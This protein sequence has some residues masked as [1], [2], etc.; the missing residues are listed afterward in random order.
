M[1][2]LAGV[3]LVVL[4]AAA[5]A[6]DVRTWRVGDA[7]HPWRAVPV[8]TIVSWGQGWAVEVLMDEDGDGLID[9]D[10]VE[11]IDDDGDG[12]FNEDP[13][14]EQRD[15]DGDGLVNEDPRN[16]IDDD[17]DGLIDE[18]PPEIFDNDRDGL[19]NEDGPD[20][21]IDN[22]G[23]G[24]LN[25]D[26]LWT[27]T[28]D[29]YDGRLNEDPPEPGGPESQVD[30]DGDGLVNEDPYGPMTGTR[31]TDLLR[32]DPVGDDDCYRLP[33]NVLDLTACDG[34]DEDP[35]NGI[36]DDG[37]GRVDEDGLA[38]DLRGVSTWLSPVQLDSRREFTSLLAGRQ[39]RAEY[40]DGMITAPTE[41]PVR[42]MPSNAFYLPR[43]GYGHQAGGQFDAYAKAF[44]GNIYTAYGSQ[45]QDDAAGIGYRLWGYYFINRLVLRPRPSLPGATPR[46]Y[47]ILY[48]DPS[49][50]L[51]ET[52][53][54]DLILVPL[55]QGE[56]NVIVK[57]LRFNPPVTMGAWYF[58]NY[59]PTGQYWE[60]AEIGLFGDGYPT[61]GFYASEI[62]DVGIDPVRVRRYQYQWDRYNKSD[63][64]AMDA[65]FP[66]SAPG[67]LVTWGR[68]R[69]KGR[70]TGNGK[71]DVRIQFRA[72]DTPDTYVWQRSLGAGLGDSRNLDGTPIDA[73][74]WAKLDADFL[75]RLPEQQLPY[76]ELGVA[77][78]G[79]DGAK[80][81]SYW[82][83]PLR[84][85]DGL[86]DTT[87]PLAG[88]GVLLT[89][90]GQTRYLQFRIYFDSDQYGSNIFDWIEFDYDDPVVSNGLLAEVY[91]PRAPLG[92]AQEFRYYIR[93][94]FL[95]ASGE[96]G[97]NRIEVVVPDSSTVL[98]ALRVD[99]ALWRPIQLP[100]KP[101][102]GGDPLAAVEPR[103]LS[104]SEAEYA[105]A[106]LQDDRTG[107]VRLQ[108]KVPTLNP[109]T[110]NGFAPGQGA[111]IELVFTST[112]FSGS[113]RFT[114]SVWSDAAGDSFIPQPTVPGDASPELSTDDIS[115]VADEI[116][117]LLGAP[118]VTP[119]PFSPNRDGVNDA[120][121]FTFGL[122]L[123]TEPVE[124]RLEIFDLSGRPVRI[125]SDYRPASQ[126]RLTWDGTDG[127]GNLVPPG[128]YLYRLC[129]MDD[130]GTGDRLGTVAVAY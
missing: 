11:L 93:P 77:A 126:V 106:V 117:Q 73:F 83:A 19:L 82:T 113:A 102:A 90:P 47:V 52:Q 44:D 7:A 94:S 3:L 116:R 28:D 76:N 95:R 109:Q 72:G 31:R 114:S 99:D 18:D 17:G 23:D 49:N 29:D 60:I 79:N 92:E 78:V 61:D 56:K 81:W 58:D 42:T 24:L 38:D 57:D 85:A 33:N 100:A 54:T 75:E 127:T 98:S 27:F 46:D 10:P 71:G 36:D 43:S 67:K 104:P 14:D 63:R 96:T 119:N 22:D 15:T 103:F 74:T 34:A 101:A 8:S 59:L 37:D 16:G 91:P 5:A 112:L 32:Y 6:A 69:W 120:V 13:E 68:V 87:Q 118:A 110:V 55:V 129:A 124:V 66:E 107:G 4:S 9:E 1:A 20:E 125:L 64:A 108:I 128:L 41:G 51:A 53:R 70:Q 86:V 130:H 84:F 12:L 26:G 35:F 123:V 115:V 97:F 89:L 39:A 111:A 105:Y 25:E 40:G 62:I 30:N 48:G 65:Q 121:V 122:F 21:Q 50:V 88:Q 80:G 2:K 45:T